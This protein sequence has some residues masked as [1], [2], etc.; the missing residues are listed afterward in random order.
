VQPTIT[1]AIEYFYGNDVVFIPPDKIQWDFV[2]TF[3]CPSVAWI[4][5]IAGRSDF[6]TIK[7]SGIGIVDL[8]NI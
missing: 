4:S 8:T 6:N 2:F 7:K 1:I 5:R 3:F